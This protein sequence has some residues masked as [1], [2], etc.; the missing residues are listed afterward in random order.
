MLLNIPPT[1]EGLFHD[2]DVQV[3]KEFKNALDQIF[4]EDLALGKIVTASNTRLNHPKF[5]AQNITDDND[6][7]YWAADD[8]ITEATLK[9]DL[10]EPTVFDHIVLQEP[11]RFGQ[12]IARFSIEI[13]QNDKW[14]TLEQGT[15]IGYKRILRT[16]VTEGSKIRL[17]IEK[18]LNTPAI[19][20]F[21][22]YKSDL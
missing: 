18:S 15:T 13:L 9:I 4:T 6:E 1:P 2:R 14:I 7:N 17:V 20:N 5:A 12:R 21:S 19:S 11:I 8:G 16:P 22:I 10:G 3:L